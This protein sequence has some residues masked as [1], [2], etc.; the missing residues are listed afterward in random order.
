MKLITFGQL[1]VEKGINYSR[2][3]L[4]RKCKAGEFPKPIPI[5]DKRIAW[6][7]TEVEAWLAAKARERDGNNPSEAA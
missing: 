6:D 4:R 7:E 3:H 2:D 5:S 1:A